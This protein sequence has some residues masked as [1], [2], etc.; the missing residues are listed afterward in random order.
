[1]EDQVPL[2][3]SQFL[4]VA[5]IYCQINESNTGVVLYKFSQTLLQMISEKGITSWSRGL[6]GAIGIVKQDNVSIK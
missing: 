3:W 6:L 2:L 5:Y 1:M 4:N